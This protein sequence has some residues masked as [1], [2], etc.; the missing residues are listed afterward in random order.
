M[1]SDPR[2]IPISPRSV[3]EKH[4]GTA[5]DN[6]S[7]IHV[8]ESEEDRSPA[9]A[10]TGS[11]RLRSNGAT[12]VSVTVVDTVLPGVASTVADPFSTHGSSNA[13][14]E[15]AVAAATV[16]PSAAATVAP[17]ASGPFKSSLGPAWRT[18][19]SPQRSWPS[20][21][22]LHP[23][24]LGKPVL[25]PS[26]LPDSPSASSVKSVPDPA[27]ISPVAAP[28]RD[29]RKRQPPPAVP[30]V[31]GKKVKFLTSRPPVE[32]GVCPTEFIV[33]AHTRVTKEEHN[34]IICRDRQDSILDPKSRAILLRV[35]QSEARAGHVPWKRIITTA[36]ALINK[37]RPEAHRAS[38]SLREAKDVIHFML[39][40]LVCDATEPI[41]IP[42]SFPTSYPLAS[43]GEY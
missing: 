34:T 30:E 38:L 17:S 2:G 11:T 3:T 43:L 32:R 6:G 27:D 5:F 42:R 16:A 21:G 35:F 31:A 39:Y 22:F 23:A 12:N 13:V 37:D 4:L 14:S 24:G 26:A 10:S 9:H 40:R 25:P 33:A 20:Q 7:F 28:S 29:P 41:K 8:D 15:S 36:L 1:A 19:A 18:L